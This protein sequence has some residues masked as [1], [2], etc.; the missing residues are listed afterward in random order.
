[1]P[2]DLLLPKKLSRLW[3]VKVQDREALYEE[4]HITIW[5]KSSRYR[6]SLRRRI[7]LDPKPD[8]T[9]VPQSL[10]NHIGNHWDELC[11]AWNE[12]FPAN[13][14]EEPEEES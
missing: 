2:Y 3:R 12:R 14:V 1:M 10:L 9:D 13:P 6:F 11:D 4:P 5:R 7:F 8:P